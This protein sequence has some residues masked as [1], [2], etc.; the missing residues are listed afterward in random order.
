MRDDNFLISFQQQVNNFFIDVTC[1]CIST[2]TITMS[3]S[4]FL[5]WDDGIDLDAL[6]GDYTEDDAETPKKKAKDDQGPC[7]KCPVCS[8][9]LKTIAGFRGHTS[10]QHDQPN[11]KGIYC[12]SH[13]CISLD[14]I[15]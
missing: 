5:S 11:L 6:L 15:M 4:G 10:K 14:Y 3:K 1:I 13:C 2:C 8:K 7:F 9:A 12:K